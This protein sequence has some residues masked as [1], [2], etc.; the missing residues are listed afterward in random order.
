MD[1]S[2]HTSHSCPPPPTPNPFTY[3]THAHTR[4]HTDSCIHVVTHPPTLLQNTHTH[5]WVLPG[6]QRLTYLFCKGSQWPTLA[7]GGQPAKSTVCSPTAGIMQNTELS[8][9]FKIFFFNLLLP[10][11]SLLGQIIQLSVCLLLIPKLGGGSTYHLFCRLV[12]LQN[13]TIK[14]ALAVIKMA[15]RQIW[16]RAKTRGNEGARGIMQGLHSVIQWKSWGCK[17]TIFVSRH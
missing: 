7:I 13:T 17:A 11:I 12:F 2:G 16:R 1:L 9:I 4:L 6:Y 3:R 5:I 14:I 8:S 10:R 15:Q